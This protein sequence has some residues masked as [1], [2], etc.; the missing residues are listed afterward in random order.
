VRLPFPERIPLNRV[1]IF[2]LVLFAVQ[3]VEGTTLY[4]S[5]GCVAFILL[6]AVAFNAGGGLTRTAGAY[7]F[8]YSVL[9][10]LIGLCYKAFLGEAADLGLVDPQTDIKAYVAGMAAMLA[11]VVVSR[12]LRP[13]TSLLQN[14]LKERNAYRASVGCIAFGAVGAF[15]IGLL[16]PSAAKLETAFYQ[17]NELIPLGIIIAVM[18]QIRSSGGTRSTSLLTI[19]AAGY[20]FFFYGVLG[21]SK[22][23][24]LTPFFCWAL[25]ICALRFRLSITQMGACLVGIFIVFHYLTPIAQVGKGQL[26]ETSTFSQRVELGERL[27]ADP[28]RT[29]RIYLESEENPN[30]R[31]L[32]SYYST[33][34]GFWERL[35]FISVDDKLNNATDQGSVFGLLPVED[36][37]L[38]VVPHF[39]W[40]NKPGGN[41][42]NQY[43]HDLNGVARDE[44]DVTT[45]ISFSPTGEAYHLAQWTGILVIAP[46]LWCMLFVAWD[47]LLGDLRTTPWGMLALAL[48]AHTAP[49]GGI[50]GAIHLT[51]FGSEILTFCAL[52]AAWLG[53]V[54]AIPV[55]GPDRSMVD[56]EIIQAPRRAPS[57]TS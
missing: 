40:P 4:F 30:N 32:S 18:Y 44:G 1:A 3:M 52:F 10:V 41:F 8:F 35:Q 25:P 50:T 29:R 16:G 2:A 28:A 5:A 12:R 13:K 19:V 23:G 21:F 48:L 20:F 38:N 27:V 24:M 34:Q 31:G 9:V 11:A 22:Q 47:S 56:R 57:N 36:E 49:E 45:G 54:L 46:L 17:L 6:A 33:P 26:S 55:L 42:G 14:V 51:T 53:P 7:V 37:F 43:A 15:L 39:I